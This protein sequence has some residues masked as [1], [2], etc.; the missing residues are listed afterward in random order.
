MLGADKVFETMFTQIAQADPSGQA[1]LNHGGGRLRHQNL[2]ACAHG[3]QTRRAVERSA[4]VVAVAQ[5]GLARVQRHAH[6]QG[7]GLAPGLRLQTPLAGG[8][9]D[10]AV[11]GRGKDSIQAIAGRLDDLAVVGLD[12]GA[13]DNVMPGQGGLHLFRMPVPKLGA[14]LDIGEE[15]GDGAGREACEH[16]T[17]E[18]A[19]AGESRWTSTTKYERLGERRQVTAPGHHH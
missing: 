9:G 13:Q 2:P 4:V 11:E 16:A 10:D 18:D 1:V 12:G 19:P 14:A 6:A 5:L 8:D 15:E 17:S 3:H 7:A